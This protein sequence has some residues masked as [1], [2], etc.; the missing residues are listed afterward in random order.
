ML[1]KQEGV[2]QRLGGSNFK[3]IPGK[4]DAG[5]H[6]PALS[7]ALDKQHGRAD[8][9]RVAGYVLGSHPISSMA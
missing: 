4:T 8:P 7:M 1:G 3:A 2:G 9:N 6:L 5:Q